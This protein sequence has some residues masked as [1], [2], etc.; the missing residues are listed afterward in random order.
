MLDL[1]Y[2]Q[3]NLIAEL[4]RYFYIYFKIFVLINTL[5]QMVQQ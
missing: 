4:Y 1:L 3:D 2:N 5:R